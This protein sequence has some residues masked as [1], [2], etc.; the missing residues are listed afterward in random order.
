M[1]NKE[2]NKLLKKVEATYS[3]EL[4]N[5]RESLALSREKMDKLVFEKRRRDTNGHF[6][7]RKRKI[8]LKKNITQLREELDQKS[9]EKEESVQNAIST[10]SKENQH[11]KDSILSLR[12]RNMN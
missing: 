1:P 7:K 5:L 2:S 9:I 3:I 12:A 11:L 4:K 6:F 10:V 8:T